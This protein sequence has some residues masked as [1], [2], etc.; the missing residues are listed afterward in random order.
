MFID[1]GI[2]IA[3]IVLLS[4]TIFMPIKTALRFSMYRITFNQNH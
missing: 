1:E 2:I 3:H 4:K